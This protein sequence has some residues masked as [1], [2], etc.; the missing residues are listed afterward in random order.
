M[1]DGDQERHVHFSLKNAH[2]CLTTAANPSPN[3]NLDR[4]FRLRLISRFLPSLIT[5]CAAV[6][7]NL[8]CSLIGVNDIVK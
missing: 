1:Q 5:A 6:C 7:L 8:D 2:I 3:M 4:M